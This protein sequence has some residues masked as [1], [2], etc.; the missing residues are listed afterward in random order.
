VA[1]CA[2]TAAA[3]AVKDTFLYIGGRSE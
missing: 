1:A 3:V 2:S